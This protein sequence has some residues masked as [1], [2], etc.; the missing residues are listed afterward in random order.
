MSLESILH[1]LREIDEAHPVLHVVIRVTASLLVAVLLDW[2]LV[3]LARRAANRT[4][5]P[6]DDQLVSHLNRPIL[7]TLFLAGAWLSTSG[8]DYVSELRVPIFRVALTLLAVQWS[9]AGVRVSRAALEVIGR[10]NAVASKNRND[11]RFV[12]KDTLPLFENL[13]TIFVLG[14]A[15]YLVLL[16]WNLDV[17]GWIASAGIAGIALG[18]AAQDSLANLFAGV[19]IF[20][21]RPYRI[22]DM[23]H[24]E[25]GERGRVTHVGLRSTR[26]LT[27]DHIQITIPNA[28][29][30]NAK[31]INES[32]GPSPEFRIRAAVGVAYGT[33]IEQAR[34]VLLESAQHCE[35]LLRDPPPTIRLRALSESSVDFEILG[36]IEDPDARGRAIDEMLASAYTH[37]NAAKIEIPYAKRDIYIKEMPPDTARRP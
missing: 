33:D 22:H 19:F 2:S 32:G 31:I 21:D 5:T 18:F 17:S 28:T 1:W 4:A 24:L 23:I 20:A 9:I 8:I 27:R 12:S 14:A 7:V 11:V 25:S 10:S 15:T 26:I 36:W 34:Q 13:A 29:M 35:S 16:V 30:A 37:L 3:K 6:L